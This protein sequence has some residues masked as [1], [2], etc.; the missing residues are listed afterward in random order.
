MFGDLYAIVISLYENLLERVLKTEDVALIIEAHFRIVA[1][2]SIH[3][4]L[5]TLCQ[6]DRVVEHFNRVMKKCCYLASRVWKGLKKLIG[7]SKQSKP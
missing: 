4:M 5:L 3:R 2:K 7:I 6:A 1:E